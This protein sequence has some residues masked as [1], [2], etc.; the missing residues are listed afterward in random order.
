MSGFLRDV[1]ARVPLVI[2]LDD[3]HWAD[4]PTLQ[5]L[6]HIAREIGHAR[7]LLLGTYRDTDLDRTHPLSQ[8]LGALN[9]EALFTRITLRGL[10]R[11]EVGAFISARGARRSRSRR[12]W[13][14]STRRPRAT[15][16]SWARS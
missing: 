3:L 5:M 12:S 1:S 10:S 11:E 7:V 2:V 4:K 13:R 15:R 16:S 6:S 14:A 8:T 9:R